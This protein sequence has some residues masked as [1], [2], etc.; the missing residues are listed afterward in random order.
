MSVINPS[1]AF[2]T[3]AA[4]ASAAS[5]Q[6][7]WNGAFDASPEASEAA[8]LQDMQALSGTLS[9]A[10][11]LGSVALALALFAGASVLFRTGLRRYASASS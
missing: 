9:T 5:L 8:I 2:L 4:L 6:T 1:G 3:Q 11:L 7:S 10:M